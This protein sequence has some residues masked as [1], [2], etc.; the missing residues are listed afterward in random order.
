MADDEDDD[1]VVAE[2]CCVIIG[3]KNAPFTSQGIHMRQKSL[4]TSTGG[5]LFGP[6]FGQQPLLV[7]GT[8][9]SF[10]RT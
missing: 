7:P 1:P 8:F 6:D 2:V 9:Y 10:L 3:D 4:Y 5:R